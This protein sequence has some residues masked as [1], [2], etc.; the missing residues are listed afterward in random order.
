MHAL[1]EVV[2]CRCH[3]VFEPDMD[4]IQSGGW[5]I[6]PQCWATVASA[7]PEDDDDDDEAGDGP[8]QLGDD[9]EDPD[10]DAAA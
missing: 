3:T 8:D 5:R 7:P 10:P 1:L 6:C 2:Y 9:D 4:S